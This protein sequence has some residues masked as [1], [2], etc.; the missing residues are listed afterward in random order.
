M[1]RLCRLPEQ[2]VAASQ[3]EERVRIGR[4]QPRRRAELLRR[5]CV[6]ARREEDKKR[7]ARVVSSG[8]PAEREWLWRSEARGASCTRPPA[9]RSAA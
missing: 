4:L 1:E 6:P 2:L 3:I 9:S 8:A 5:L 7:R